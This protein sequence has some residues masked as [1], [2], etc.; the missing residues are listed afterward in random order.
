M[1]RWGLGAAAWADPAA[2]NVIHFGIRLS[3]EAALSGLGLP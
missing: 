3:V 1:A 2:H